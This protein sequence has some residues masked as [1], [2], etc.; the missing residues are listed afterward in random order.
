[1]LALS[2]WIA[3]Y[4]AHRLEAPLNQL[5]LDSP[6]ENVVYGEISPHLR[7]IDHQQKELA[8]Q[9]QLL[10]QKKGE[11]DTIISKI[12]EGMVLLDNQRRIISM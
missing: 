10:T 9:E 4:T 1:L 7:R 5:D 11:F 8:S 6:M 12:R 2:I 3:R